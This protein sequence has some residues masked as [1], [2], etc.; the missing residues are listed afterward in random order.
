MKTKKNTM[1]QLFTNV[2]LLCLTG[3]DGKMLTL[4]HDDVTCIIYKALKASGNPDR[5]LALNLADKVIYRLTNWQGHQK[6]LTLHDVEYMIRFVLSEA[7]NNEASKSVDAVNKP[8]N[9]YN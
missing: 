8:V 4:D 1:A 2:D 9:Q 6:P 3:E 5:L 7:G